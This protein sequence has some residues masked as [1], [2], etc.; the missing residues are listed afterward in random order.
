MIG[1]GNASCAPA[2]TDNWVVQKIAFFDVGNNEIAGVES[3]ILDGTFATDVWHVNA[4]IIGYAPAG[5]VKVQAL[6]LYLQ[7]LFDG[8][9]AH[10]DDVAFFQSGTVGTHESTWGNIKALY[11]E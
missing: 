7:P 4:P 8:G 1:I 6:I 11:G 3:V 2:C 10:I 9:A 5:A